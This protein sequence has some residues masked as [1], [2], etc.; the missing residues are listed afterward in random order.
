MPREWYELIPELGNS[1][2]DRAKELAA[3]KTRLKRELQEVM[4]A[5]AELFIEIANCGHWS[6]KEMAPVLAR[7]RDTSPVSIPAPARRQQSK[8]Q[9]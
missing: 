5:E 3:S 7:L 1:F 8:V 4:D 9:K 6:R 2:N